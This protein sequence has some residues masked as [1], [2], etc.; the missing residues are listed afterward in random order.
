MQ[1]HLA[2]QKMILVPEELMRGVL[3]LGVDEVL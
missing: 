2:E 3:H 1:R